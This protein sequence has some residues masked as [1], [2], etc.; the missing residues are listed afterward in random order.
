MKLSRQD[1]CLFFLLFFFIF[2]HAAQV[3][4]E[5]AKDLYIV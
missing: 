2:D 3:F 4:K 1:C 5:E